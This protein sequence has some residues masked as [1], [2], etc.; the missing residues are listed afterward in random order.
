MIPL[1]IPHSMCVSMEAFKFAHPNEAD[2]LLS[3]CSPA[4]L[5]SPSPGSGPPSRLIGVVLMFTS[6]LNFRLNPTSPAWPVCDQRWCS[7]SLT[8]GP[9]QSRPKQVS[10]SES[11]GPSSNAPVCGT[12][13]ATVFWFVR[14]NWPSTVCVRY[15]K[16]IFYALPKLLV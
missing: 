11:Y 1:F 15:G 3:T 8:R 7:P 6:P 14:I 12:S 5:W 9:Y 13:S 4:D 16:H 10:Q 2:L